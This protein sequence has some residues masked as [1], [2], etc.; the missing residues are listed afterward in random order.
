M[1]EKQLHQT[2]FRENS[3]EPQTPSARLLDLSKLKDRKNLRESIAYLKNSREKSNLE[4]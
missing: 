3:V 2:S 1:T 4:K